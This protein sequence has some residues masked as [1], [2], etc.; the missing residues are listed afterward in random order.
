MPQGHFQFL[1]SVYITELHQ[2]RLLPAVP[3]LYPHSKR[4][5]CQDCSDFKFYNFLWVTDNNRF[6][7]AMY[8]GYSCQACC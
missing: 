8:T 3:T 2:A 4:P 5:E 6:L 1:S 7:Y